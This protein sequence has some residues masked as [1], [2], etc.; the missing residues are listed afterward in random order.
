MGSHARRGLSLRWI[1]AIKMLAPTAVVVAAGKPDPSNLVSRAASPQ[2]QPLRVPL[3]FEANDGRIDAR[4]KAV[5]RAGACSFFLTAD[6]ATIARAN[7]RVRLSFLGAS[8]DRSVVPVD[9]L[10]GVTNYLVGQD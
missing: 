1:A 6:G 3:V 9:R 4:V 2:R 10:S 5:A 7:D 8:A